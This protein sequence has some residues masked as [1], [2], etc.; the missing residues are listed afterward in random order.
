MVINNEVKRDAVRLA[1]FL[2]GQ[3]SRVF[4]RCLSVNGERSI[5]THTR[6]YDPFWATIRFI[7]FGT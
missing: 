5:E 3:V 4:V 1:L 6:W 7:G 2:R